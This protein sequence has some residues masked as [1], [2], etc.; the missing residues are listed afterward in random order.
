VIDTHCHLDVAAFDEDRDAVIA[1]AGAAG[2]TG[3]LI[4]GIRPR[5]WAALGALARRHAGGGVRFAVGVHPQIVPELGEDE[6]GGD[7][8]ERIARASEDAVAIGECGLDGGT[9][10]RALQE[11]IFRAHVRVARA[12]GKP[13]V[14]HVLRAHDAAPRILREERA[15]DCGVVLHSYSGGAALVAVYAGLGCAFS[16]AGPVTYPNARR[17]IEA[18]RA[19]PA[20]LLLAETDAPDQTPAAHRAGRPASG[21]AASSRERARSA[22]RSEPAHL[23]AVIAGLAAARGA[24][25]AEVAALTAANAARLFRTWSRAILPR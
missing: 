17:P 5:T 8:E 4:P 12:L 1:R 6:R 25:P 14:V 22:G 23:P 18:A 9:G 19:V 16:F 10:E 20:E 11:R 24:A 2:V 7:L 15:G 3:M 13:L 21:E